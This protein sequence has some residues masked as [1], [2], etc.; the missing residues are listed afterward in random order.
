MIKWLRHEYESIFEDGSGEMTVSRG[1]AHEHLGMTLDYSVRGQVKVSQFGY[2]KEIIIAFDKAEPNGAGTKTSA[3]PTNLF[4]VNK[5]CKKLGQ[6]KATEFHNLVAKTLCSTKRSRPD[7]SLATSFLAT[8]V[9]SPNKDDWVKLTHLMQHLR[10]TKLL[11]L[12]LSA[13]GSGILKWWVDASFAVHPNMRGHSGGGLPMG[14]GFPMVGANK[15]RINARSSTETEIVGAN[16]FMPLTCWT[17]LFM[18]AQ[19]YKVKDNILFQDNKSSILLEKNGKASS[20]KRTKHINIRYCC[21]VD[22]VTSGDLSILWCPTGDMIADFA[23]KPLQGAL[24]RK[25]RDQIMGVV[26]AQDPGPGKSKPANGK[27]KKNK[28]EKGKPTKGKNKHGAAK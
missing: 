24:F 23:T 2:I 18:E 8:R 1:K 28:P 3:A 11:G 12:T 4:T 15:Q 25:F 14:R 22:R 17:H 13:N 20:S 6:Q 10:S 16:D 7:T 21:I 26:P 19:G 5:D 9:R 27:P